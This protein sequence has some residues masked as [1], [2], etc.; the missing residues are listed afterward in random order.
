MTVNRKLLLARDIDEG[1]IISP[2]L[3]YQSIMKAV[4]VV[5]AIEVVETADA[6]EVYLIRHLRFP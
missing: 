2:T 1:S 6:V 3:Y 5:E 4:G